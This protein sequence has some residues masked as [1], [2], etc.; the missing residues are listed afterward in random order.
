VTTTETSTGATVR[1][2]PWDIVIV[3][4]PGET[5]FDA[6]FRAGW[7]WPTTCYGQAQCT[8]CHMK[9]LTDD[10]QLEPPNEVERLIV[11]RLV[12]VSYRN[13]PDVCI[14]LACQTRPTDDLEVEVKQSPER[15]ST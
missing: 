10:T 11:G 9:V 5:V 14:R 12:R 6:A 4:Q 8:R 1:V 13:D 15:R 2:H 7:I 3:V